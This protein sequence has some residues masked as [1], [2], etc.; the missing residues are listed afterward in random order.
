MGN[1]NKNIKMSNNMKSQN[2]DEYV[3]FEATNKIDLCEHETLGELLTSYKKFLMGIID[4]IRDI[5]YIDEI[6]FKTFQIE[7]NFFAILTQEP[8]DWMLAG[9][10]LGLAFSYSPKDTYYILD[11]IT[12]NKKDVCIKTLSAKISEI[13]NALI[14]IAKDPIKKLS[15]EKI[16]KL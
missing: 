14:Q 3:V 12:W 10:K 7:H 1:K 16:R 15:K 2:C 9:M 4:E 13:T 6:C 5:H 11:E 8:L